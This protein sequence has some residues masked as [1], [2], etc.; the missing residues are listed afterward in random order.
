MAVFGQ[1]FLNGG[2]YAGVR[3]LSPAAVAAM[4]RDQVPG[5]GAR[6]GTI[7]GERASWGYGWQITSP[8]KWKYFEGSLQPL[9]T[10]GHMGA[11]AVSCWIDRD[12]DLVGVY[13][14]VVT[15][16]TADSMIWDFDLFQNAIT[17]AVDG[18]PKT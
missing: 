5:I 6:I 14:E 16:L 12:D 17:A 11:G 1:M 9:G 7:D 13:F 10:F 4:T 15:R 2:R 3:V 18:V 8:S